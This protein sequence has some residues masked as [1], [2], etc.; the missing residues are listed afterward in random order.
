MDFCK[1]LRRRKCHIK[2]EAFNCSEMQ[3]QRLT[4]DKLSC[5][6]NIWNNKWTIHISNIM[7][8]FNTNLPARSNFLISSTEQ[9]ESVELIKRNFSEWLSHSLCHSE[10]QMATVVFNEFGDNCFASFNCSNQ[11]SRKNFTLS[12]GDSRNKIVI[13]YF[14]LKL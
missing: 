4:A 1:T 9:I 8:K 11:R 12:F 3:S 14:R 13:R 5:Y 10:N 6:S 2:Y 7:L